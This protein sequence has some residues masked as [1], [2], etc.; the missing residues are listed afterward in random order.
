MLHAFLLLLSLVSLGTTEQAASFWARQARVGTTNTCGLKDLYDYRRLQ[1]LGLVPWGGIHLS[2]FFTEGH[3]RHPPTPTGANRHAD[4]RH[5]W[6]TFCLSIGVHHGHWERSML[7][8]STD[9]PRC[10]FVLG[11]DVCGDCVARNNANIKNT[12]RYFG[13]LVFARVDANFGELPPPSSV[14]GWALP[15]GKPAPQKWDMVV[16]MSSLHHLE[17]LEHVLC[18]VCKGLR[19]GSQPGRLFLNEYVGSNR[20]M[21]ND[22]E[23]LLIN[24]FIAAIGPQKSTG[25]PTQHYTR[26]WY[27][28]MPGNDNSESIRALDIEPVIADTGFRIVT[29]S[30]VHGNFGQHVLLRVCS[31]FP[32]AWDDHQPVLAQF[33][34]RER[35]LLEAGKVPYVTLVGLYDRPD[36]CVC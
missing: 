12:S 2:D 13:R 34:E 35:G 3:N 30:K 22:E 32:E 20:I 1:P 4:A 26:D 15:E 36:R 7:S 31:V 19:P 25:L 18:E 14:T 24:D 17:A 5:A 21:F 29:K 6:P 10:S 9:L 11:V 33:I 8:P 23:L 27:I 28:S 16:F